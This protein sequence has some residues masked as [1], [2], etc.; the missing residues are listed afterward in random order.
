MKLG[1]YVKTNARE[2]VDGLSQ[3]GWRFTSSRQ[4]SL[5]AWTIS[6]ADWNYRDLPH[7][8]FIHTRVDG[9]LT[10]AEHDFTSSILV[11]KIGPFRTLLP[12]V[13]MCDSQHG[14]VYFTA[15]GGIA[16]VIETMWREKTDE[17]GCVV[18]TTYYVGTRRLLSFVRPLIHRMLA[19]NYRILM[20]EDLPMREARADLRQRGFSFRQDTEGHSYVNSMKIGVDNLILPSSNGSIIFSLGE[21]GTTRRTVW[22]EEQTRAVAASLDNGELRIYPAICPH[23]GAPLTDAVCNSSG[24]LE[25]PWHGRA[26]ST[27]VSL[28]VSTLNPE[29]K[30]SFDFDSRELTPI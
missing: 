11:Q 6:D 24:R 26:F 9:V 23:E 17:T 29:T 16:L 10:C 12:V 21:I 30:F 5:G 18:T 7:L 1:D 27:L 28:D 4:I 8:N 13:L 22:N 20:K 2:I 25:C 19:K 3:Y 15:N 14:Q